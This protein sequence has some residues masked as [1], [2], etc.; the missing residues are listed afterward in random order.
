MTKLISKPDFKTR[1]CYT[2]YNGQIV[3]VYETFA[4]TG[5]QVSQTRD[6][7]IRKRIDSA[8][9]L[10]CGDNFSRV[11]AKNYKSGDIGVYEKILACKGCGNWIGEYSTSI[12]GAEWLLPYIRG[13]CPHTQIPALTALLDELSDSPK[14]AFETSP[15][16]FELFVG[17]VLSAFFNCEVYHVGKSRDGGIDLVAVGADH[18]LMIQV[19]RRESPNAVEGVEV[20]R[21]LFASMFVRGAKNGMIVTTAHHFSKDAKQWIH[22]PALKD[23]SYNI[24]LVAFDRLLQMT[25]SVRTDNEPPWTAAITFWRAANPYLKFMQPFHSA[26]AVVA[27]DKT[28]ISVEEYLSHRDTTPYWLFDGG[29]IVSTSQ[30]DASRVFAFTDDDRS[31]CYELASEALRRLNLS[32]HDTPIVQIL[33]KHEASKRRISGSAFDEVLRDVPIGFIEQMIERWAKNDLQNVVTWR[34]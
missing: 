20:V 17:S 11:H 7:N 5:F 23:N 16:Q 33:Q 29:A 12:S 22:L 27:A 26:M 21:L 3:Q 30:G 10:L 4:T 34:F 8:N 14:R 31:G 32:E 18:P 28:S 2:D 24:D 6:L 25:N 13:F 15:K 19:K 9:C 1:Q